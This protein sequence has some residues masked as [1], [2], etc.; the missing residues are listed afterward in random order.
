MSA[1][2][3]RIRRIAG[4]SAAPVAIVLA[5]L[6]VWQ[7]SSAAFTAKTQNVGNNWATGSVSLS[8]DDQGSALFTVANVVPG[9]EGTKCIK[10]TS[11]ASVPGIVRL[12]QSRVAMD[13]L[14]Q[15]IVGTLQKGTGGTFGGGCGGFVADPGDTVYPSQAF[16]TSDTPQSF[17][18]AAASDL[19]WNTTGNAQGE[20]KTY[21]FYWKFD[22]TGLTQAQIDALQGKSIS[23]D[24]VWEFQSN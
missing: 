11:T 20:T 9:Q 1:P 21:K 12:Y 22:T 2:S 23:T 3:I 18:Q 7:G 24:F 13:G 16:V 4:F 17:A 8:D 19:D 5:G 6:L 14:E 15:Y 10:V